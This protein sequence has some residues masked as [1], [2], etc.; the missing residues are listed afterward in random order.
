MDAYYK[1]FTGDDDEKNGGSSR[2]SKWEGSVSTLSH[3]ADM[4]S[5]YSESKF[6]LAFALIENH[7]LLTRF[8]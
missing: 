7:Y 4:V 5:S 1:I 8:S 3:K 6:A 2:W